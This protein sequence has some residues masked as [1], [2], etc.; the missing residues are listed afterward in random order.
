MVCPPSNINLF[1]SGNL[2]FS[3]VEKAFPPLIKM[4]GWLSCLCQKLTFMKS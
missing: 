4:D 1:V 2:S 3:W